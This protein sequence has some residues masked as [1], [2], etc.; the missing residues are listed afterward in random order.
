MKWA[1]AELLMP[2][3]PIFASAGFYLMSVIKQAP[4]EPPIIKL[5][6]RWLP[7]C[8][9]LLVFYLCRKI[10]TGSI[11]GIQDLYFFIARNHDRL[12]YLERTSNVVPLVSGIVL[13]VVELFSDVMEL[14]S[15]T[16]LLVSDSSTSLISISKAFIV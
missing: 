3:L 5:G 1:P 12:R 16:A 13:V 2:L 14:S 10:K 7:W 8:L 15:G 9:L 6:L 4:V 11:P